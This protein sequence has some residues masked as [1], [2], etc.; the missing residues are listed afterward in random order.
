MG[1]AKL[2]RTTGGLKNG[3]LEPDHTSAMRVQ[4][5]NKSPGWTRATIVRNHA[6][7]RE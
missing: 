7:L 6:I 2:V 3:T 5:C 1:R 4:W